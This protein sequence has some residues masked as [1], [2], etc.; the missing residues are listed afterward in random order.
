M[1]QPRFTHYGIWSL[2]QGSGQRKEIQ[3]GIEKKR[4]RRLVLAGSIKRCY[5]GEPSKLSLAWHLGII[6]MHPYSRGFCREYNAILR[7]TWKWYYMM[8]Y[9]ALCNYPNSAAINICLIFWGNKVWGEQWELW[10][11]S[12]GTF[13][14]G[15]TPHKIWS[16]KTLLYFWYKHNLMYLGGKKIRSWRRYYFL[17]TAFSYSRGISVF[18]T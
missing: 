14:K 8:Q 10:V 11:C 7:L 17:H 16:L 1:R 4:E 12:K 2:L 6:W 5:R 3:K 9:E 18:I 13:T 15:H